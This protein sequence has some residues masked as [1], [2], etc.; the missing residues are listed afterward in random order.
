MRRIASEYPGYG[1]ERNM[2]YPTPEHRKAIVELGLT[3]HH[4]RS[5]KPCQP[6]LFDY[7]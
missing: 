1:W 2:G 5:Y 4:R 7:I 3:P 6:T